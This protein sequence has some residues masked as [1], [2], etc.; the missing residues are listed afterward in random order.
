MDK[1][2]FHEVIVCYDVTESRRRKK[3]FEGLKDIGLMPLQKSV[4]HGWLMLTDEKD[5]NLLFERVL[6]KE[7][8]KAFC[9]RTK[10]TDNFSINTFGHKPFEIQELKSYDTI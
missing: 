9:I 10:L 6:D 8:D 3:L 1:R 5:V 4:F 2:L 7:T